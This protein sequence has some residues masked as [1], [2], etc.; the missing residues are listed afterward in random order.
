MSMKK[1]IKYIISIFK[2]IYF[3][4]R[5][6][7]YK[8]AIKMPIF[9][10]YN[11]KVSI[12]QTRSVFIQ[13]D[14]ITFAMIK[15]GFGG[16]D[17]LS[18]NR[19]IF[20]VKKDAKIIFKGK[21]F[22]SEGIA[23]SLDEGATLIIGEN[24]SCNKNCLFYANKNICFGN[25]VLLGWSVTIR[26]NDGHVIFQNGQEKQNAKEINIGSNVWIASNVDIL[27]G[28][29]VKENSI[30]ATRSCVTK[31]F[32]KSNILIGGY[33]AKIIGENVSWKK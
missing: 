6:L 2:T 13:S 30:I 9:I 12:K 21:A 4:F 17:F 3:N 7:D 27:K 20:E 28:V 11:T 25:D 24:F 33:P 16:T 26:D 18:T 14:K 19:S 8:T 5:V 32:D 23:I 1:I 22:F 31:S 15:I 10:A 29:I